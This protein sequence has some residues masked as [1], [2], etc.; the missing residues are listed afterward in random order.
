MNLHVPITQPRP[1]STHGQ[2]CFTHTLTHSLLLLFLSK[3][4]MSCDFTMG[5]K[6]IVLLTWKLSRI[7]VNSSD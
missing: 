3:L 1:L 6:N 4:L 2:S 5:F 7:D